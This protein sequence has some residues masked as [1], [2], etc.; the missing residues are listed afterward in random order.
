MLGAI[1][2][3]GGTKV[4]AVSAAGVPV[5]GSGRP[6]PVLRLEANPARA[7]ELKSPRDESRNLKDYERM[8]SID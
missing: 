4:A 5:C 2:G 7:G 3:P 8:C 1:V 6:V